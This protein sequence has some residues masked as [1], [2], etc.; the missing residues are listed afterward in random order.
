[1]NR[2]NRQL[3]AIMFTDIVGY[4]AL[5]GS[6]ENKALSVLKTN[7]SIH[8][9]L[10]KRYGGTWLKEMGDGTLASFKT[11][12]DSVYCAGELIKECTS[13]NIQLTIG[14]HF[15]DIVEED[16]DIFGDGVNVAS[17][18]EQI[19]SPNQI[20]VSRPIHS[21]IKNKNGIKSTFLEERE[22]K[23]VD[24]PVRIY[25]VE[26][27]RIT[28]E[29]AEQGNSE[30]SK[31]IGLHRKLIISAISV[32]VLVTAII[33]FYNH[34]KD[35]NKSNRELNLSD[36]HKSIAVLPFKDM[37][38]EQDQEYLGDGIAED[39]INR[40]TKVDD[41]KV[42]GRTSSFSF[43]EKDTDL[44]TIG[45]MLGVETILEGSVQKSE[46]QLRI[47]AQLNN[48]KDGSHI[49]SEQFNREFSDVFSLQDELAHMVVSKMLDVPASENKIFN[50]D[51]NIDSEAYE[52]FLKG[53]YFHYSKFEVTTNKEDFEAAK[54]M[55]IK[56]IEYDSTFGLPYAGLADM[57][58][59]YEAFYWNKD[60]IIA[61]QLLKQSKQYIE[62]AYNLNPHSDYVNMN[63]GFVYLQF[64]EI[65][66]AY[67]CFSKAIQLNPHSAR[68][69]FSL[70]VFYER[71]GLLNEAAILYEKAKVIDPLD[72]LILEAKAINKSVI[73]NREQVFDDL[74]EII[75]LNPKSIVAYITL[76]ILSI[77]DGRLDE[78][79]DYL[80]TI[81]ELNP[82]LNIDYYFKG[83]LY[84]AKQ[85]KK[86]ALK[87][88]SNNDWYFA[89][90]GMKEEY[91]LF[92]YNKIKSPEYSRKNEYLQYINSIYYDWVK[93]DPRIQEFVKKEK[94]KYEMLKAK[95]GN[96]NFLEL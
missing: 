66:S 80:N 93:D 22:L 63:K 39:I 46:N 54:K 14:I 50:D 34:S 12:I 91:I 41:L 18:L 35:L 62:I 95:Y 47:T 53:K 37:S 75:F 16:G 11:I 33:F 96:L 7:R 77:D 58:L 89:L 45:E 42:I 19:A 61:K 10:I 59:S 81:L 27:D 92:L 69:Y 2:S 1:M 49:W 44:I 29:K 68:N 84:A 32:F 25:E 72:I 52:F 6:D 31:N 86:N 13:Q 73:G 70:G 26:I 5:M 40:L 4:T 38:S 17:R 9:K 79:Q 3:A 74:E 8:K 64:K 51:K 78:A 57:Y 87:V 55:Y 65:D 36:V 23:N 82:E 20:I 67:Y 56:A 90:L 85:D 43:K 24:E 94:E 30:T 88:N 28:Y 60:S 21:N 76:I 71:I 83:A 15:G 48:A